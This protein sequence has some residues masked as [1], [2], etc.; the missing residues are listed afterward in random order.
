MRAKD[1]WKYFE[2]CR[3]YAFMPS[4]HEDKREHHHCALVIRGRDDVTIMARNGSVKFDNFKRRIPQSHSEVRALSRSS[5]NSIMFVVRINPSKQFRLSKPCPSC[6]A[7]IRS[8]KKIK[9]VYYSISET[10]FG[11]IDFDR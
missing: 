6:E 9:T 2:M 11:V 5:K 1:I 10:E 4:C 7:Y 3:Q 8:S